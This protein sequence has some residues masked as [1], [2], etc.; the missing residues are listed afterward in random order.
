[1]SEGA[2]DADIINEDINLARNTEGLQVAIRIIDKFTPPFI[3]PFCDTLFTWC[4]ADVTLQNMNDKNIELNIKESI[5]IQL[6]EFH[7][8]DEETKIPKKRCME[9]APPISSEVYDEPP[10]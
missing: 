10:A 3:S 9:M 2:G 7:S 4:Y 1:M 8:F 5:D 6:N